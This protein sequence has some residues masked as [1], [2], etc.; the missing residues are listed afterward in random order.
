ML[1]PSCLNLLR[2]YPLLKLW[3]DGSIEFTP[4]CAICRNTCLLVLDLA[5]K[6]PTKGWFP[7]CQSLGP[8][9]LKHL[10]LGGGGVVYP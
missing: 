2:G 7:F 8:T 5:L 10:L 4:M 9:P 3:R 6:V 1:D